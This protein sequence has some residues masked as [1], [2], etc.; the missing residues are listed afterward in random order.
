MLC[1]FTCSVL[2]LK[3]KKMKPTQFSHLGKNPWSLC[4]DK[5]KNPNSLL[6]ERERTD[7]Q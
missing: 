6:G 5:K 3:E 4:L 1:I 7:G 2:F